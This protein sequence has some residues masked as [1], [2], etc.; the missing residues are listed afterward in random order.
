M[1]ANREDLGREE[2]QGAQNKAVRFLSCDLQITTN[3]LVLV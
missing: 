1:L 3:M 2:A